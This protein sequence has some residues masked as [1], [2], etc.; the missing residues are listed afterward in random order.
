MR[1]KNP[2]MNCE[3]RHIACH[4]SCS[5][6]KVWKEEVVEHREKIQKAKEDYYGV[7]TIWSKTYRK[8]VERRK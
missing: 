3:D 2:C 5:R 7:R 6:Y 1:K 4:D 8:R